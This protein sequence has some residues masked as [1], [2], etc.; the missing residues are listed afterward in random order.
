MINNINALA[1]ESTAIPSGSLGADFTWSV[2]L[3]PLY[4]NVPLCI[5]NGLESIKGNQKVITHVVP[6]HTFEKV[7]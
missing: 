7:G 6:H 4:D 5:E 3:V 2:W 1:G